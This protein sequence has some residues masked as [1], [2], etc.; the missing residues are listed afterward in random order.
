MS[1]TIGYIVGSL[2]AE[3]VNRR[4]VGALRSLADN[5]ITFVEIPIGD[6]PLYNRDLDE[7][8]PVEALALKEAIDGSDGVLIV[9]PEYNRSV[10]GSLKNA[11]DWAS[12]PYGE[13]AFAGIPVGVI[14]ASVGSTGTSMAQQHVRNTLTFLDAPTLQQPEAF[15]HYTPQRFADDGTILDSSTREFLTDWMEAFIA[16]VRLF[17]SRDTTTEENSSAA[18][19]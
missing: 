7:D 12:R 9:T 15:I 3:S 2:S 19:S 18:A 11:L 5:N 13:N 16:W 8:Y 10:P 4:L 1:L 17:V 14:G 6:L